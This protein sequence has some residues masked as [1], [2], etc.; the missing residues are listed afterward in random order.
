[1]KV[2]PFLAAFAAGLLPLSAASASDKCDI[3]QIHG[4]R[5]LHDVLGRRAIE[6]V[7]RAAGAS[8]EVDAR[9]AQLVAPSA[10]FGLGAGDVGRPLGSGVSGAR[11]LATEMKAD[12]F[13]FLGWDYMDS[14][15]EGCAEQK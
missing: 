10:A 14:P 12:T 1:M 13:R 7:N 11:A 4:S 9:L 2:L 6:I 5:E 3:A 15:A 8:W